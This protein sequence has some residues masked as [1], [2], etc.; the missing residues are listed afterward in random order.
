MRHRNYRRGRV[1][2]HNKDAGLA[3]E[4]PHLA[5]LREWARLLSADAVFQAMQGNHEQA[6]A[7]ILA[8]MK[9][10]DALS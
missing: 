1:I 3:M 10:G 6:V 4:L 7:D 9:L 5:P 2:Q 8:S